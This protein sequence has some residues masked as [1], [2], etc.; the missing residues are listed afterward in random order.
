MMGLPILQ[1]VVALQILKPLMWLS[2]SIFHTTPSTTDLCNNKV[3][4]LRPNY[5]IGKRLCLHK[6]EDIVDITT[7]LFAL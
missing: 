3:R 5:M 7:I 2:K 6:E 1:V 4:A